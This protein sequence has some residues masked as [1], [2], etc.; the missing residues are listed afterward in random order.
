MK[1]HDSRASDARACKLSAL[2][3]PAI[4]QARKLQGGVGT[5]RSQGSSRIAYARKIEIVMRPA[6]F[7]SASR[8]ARLPF[9]H[10][11]SN[12][13]HTSLNEAHRYV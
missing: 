9:Q 12:T 8:E 3:T 2:L 5:L 6:I 11:Y 13:P 7:I 10:D 4:K 1:Q